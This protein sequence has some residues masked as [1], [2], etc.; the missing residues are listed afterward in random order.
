MLSEHFQ[1][2]SKCYE[3]STLLSE[4]TGN[5]YVEELDHEI[6]MKEIDDA[7]KCLKEDK[8]TSY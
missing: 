8:A 1:K 4:V 7:K 5:V 2:K 3:R 6:T